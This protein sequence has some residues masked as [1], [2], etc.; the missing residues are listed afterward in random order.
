MI[1]D[2]LFTY[3]LMFGTGPALDWEGV[4][5]GCAVSALPCEECYEDKS[6][7]IPQII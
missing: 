1:P 5:P 7:S 4:A 3:A 2:R 6:A